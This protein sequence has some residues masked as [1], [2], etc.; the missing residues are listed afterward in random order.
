MC[1]PTKCL[2]CVPFCSASFSSRNRASTRRYLTW[3]NRAD[4]SFNTVNLNRFGSVVSG[5]GGSVRAERDAGTPS[6]VADQL[7]VNL[8][9]SETTSH[10]SDTGVSARSASQ[11]SFNRG[12]VAAARCNVWVNGSNQVWSITQ[13]KIHFILDFDSG[14]MQKIWF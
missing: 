14:G 1:D 10:A 6:A 7:P 12:A 11:D 4:R 5:G 3:S 2:S 9:K 8:T 13:I